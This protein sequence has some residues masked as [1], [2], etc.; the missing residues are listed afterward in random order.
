MKSEQAIYRAVFS[1]II[2]SLF[3]IIFI[4]AAAPYADA[5]I[6]LDEGDLP[7]KFELKDVNG[8]PVNVTE[9][10]GR[11]P[12]VIVFWE[13]N[14]SRSFINYSLDVMRF[15]N[16]QYEKYHDSKGL[17]VFGIYTPEEAKAIPPTEY[18]SVRSMV[19]MNNIRFPVL[20]DKD[21]RIFR[22]YGVVALPSTIMI[23][24]EGRIKFIYPSFPM[25]AKKIFAEN[26][27][28]LVGIATP[29]AMSAEE[30][31][32]A[33][34]TKAKRLYRYAL[35]MYKKGL[36]E[37]ALSPL[38]KSI[39]LEPHAA[40]PHNMLGIILWKSG[41][42]DAALE[43]FEKAI[44]IDRQNAY[45]HFNYG[46]LLYENKKTVEAEKQLDI[47]MAMDADIPHTHY[48]L[49]LLYKQTGRTDEAIDML[50]RAVSLYEAKDKEAYAYDP[51]S[52]HRISAHYV[53]SEIYADKGDLKESLVHL[54]KAVKATIGIEGEES[55]KTVYR[56]EDLMIYE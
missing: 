9:H 26:I 52:F 13:K 30:E 54:R 4:S 2:I 22:E 3:I 14:M 32:R 10:F 42:F 39:S 41:Y 20:M 25:A 28:E 18:A 21:F 12:V 7:K 37:Q 11:N 38:K 17:E 53:L 27:K 24:R 48:V 34:G 16:E 35:Q 29:A 43:E 56:S 19:Q 8:A 1:T 36:L 49:G 6:G 47:S 33:A 51:D 23:N 55:R 15:M 31:E 5:L 46:L 44:Q 50:M 45:V 40:M